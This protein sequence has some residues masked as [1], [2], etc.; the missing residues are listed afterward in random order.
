M[1]LLENILKDFEATIREVAEFH[2]IT[3]TPADMNSLSKVVARYTV[4]YG[5]LEV[6][7]ND[8]KITD[9]YLDSPIGGKP[10]YI[11]HSDYGQCQTNVTFTE[12]EANS[13]IS[14][15]R[16]MS[17]RPFDEAHPVL[18]FDLPDL[19]TRV[20]VIGPPLSPSGT[21]CFSFT[22]NHSMDS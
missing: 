20:A 13:L 16:A 7:L 21:A 9:I 1:L 11:V 12:S 19:E 18:D 5:I 3:L 10:I 17:S 2:K 8:R 14:K 22:Q 4:G 6:L 15:L